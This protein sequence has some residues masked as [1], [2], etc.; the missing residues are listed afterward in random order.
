[1][2][3]QPAPEIDC[4]EPITQQ[5]MNWCAHQDFLAADAELNKQWKLTSAQVKD[6]DRAYGDA[7]NGEN[8]GYFQTLLEGQRAWLKYRDAHCASHG[9]MIGGGSM[10]PLIINS[11]KT[12]LT[13][14]RSTELGIL[15]GMDG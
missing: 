11:C 5:E 9:N 12:R 10:A 6:Q 8:P 14:L 15:I 4:E 7:T 13:K 1:M 2:A 3:S